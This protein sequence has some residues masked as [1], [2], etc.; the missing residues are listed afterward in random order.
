MSDSEST[1][2]PEPIGDSPWLWAFIFSGMALFS[3]LMMNQRID[4]RQAQ[5]EEKEHNRAVDRQFQANQAAGKTTADS[6]DEPPVATTGGG[7]SK[8][9]ISMRPLIIFFA[10]V[11][12]F[13]ALGFVWQQCRVR[14]DRAAGDSSEKEPPA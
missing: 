13:S 5:I 1:A 14:G 2:P 6:A 9:Q 10:C 4:Q 11:T 8:R 12:A 7:Y 3:L